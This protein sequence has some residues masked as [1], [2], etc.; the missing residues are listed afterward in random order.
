MPRVVHVVVT[1]NFAGV[2]R[3]VCDVANETALRGWEATVVGGDPKWMSSVL[4]GEV[5]WLSGSTTA[6]A[7]RSLARAGVQ[8]VCHAHMTLG[9][10]VAVASRP[11][12]RAPVVSTRHFAAR[13]GSSLAGRALSRWIAP[14]LAYEIAISEFVARNLERPPDAVLQ[15]AVPPSPCLWKQ[16]NRTV[17]VLQRLEREKDTMTALRAWQASRLHE[18]GWALRVVGGGSERGS[19][20]EWAKSSGLREVTFTDWTSAVAEELARAGIL[21]ASAPAEPFGLSVVEALAAGVPVVACAAGGHLETVGRLPDAR[22]F[23]PGDAEAA[24]AA[25]RSLLPDPVRTTIS[26]AARR[27]VESN[28]TIAR[29]VDRLLV[30]YETVASALSSDRARPVRSTR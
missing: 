16:T 19:L 6:Q 18:H 2:E 1:G 9:E 3:Y 13:R 20:E 11:W 25:L 7:F 29:H 28:F 22:M 23:P 12:H 17:L 10:F 14:R 8:D 26:E 30:E 21:L 24:A 4:A 15:N 5:R 27:L